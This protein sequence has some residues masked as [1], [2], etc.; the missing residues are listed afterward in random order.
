MPI[1]YGFAEV[2]KVVFADFRTS[3]NPTTTALYLLKTTNSV[4]DVAEHKG[5]LSDLPPKAA[6][7]EPSIT[8]QG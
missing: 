5:C 1:K 3:A 2:T 6:Q 4:A 7:V 8:M